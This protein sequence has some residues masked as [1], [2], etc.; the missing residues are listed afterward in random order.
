MLDVPSG[1]YWHC[2][3]ELRRRIFAGGIVSGTLAF[4]RQFWL[5]GVRF[6]DASLAEDAAFQLALAGRGARM[7]EVA[8]GNLFIYVRHTANSW[9]FAAGSFLDHRGWRMVPAPDFLGPDDVAAFRALGSPALDP[10]PPGMVRRGPAFAGSR[11]M[12]RIA[13]VR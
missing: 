2:T 12:S 5:D 13:P 8:D 4:R 7:G 9:Q 1:R 3:P 11:R 10:A 6:P